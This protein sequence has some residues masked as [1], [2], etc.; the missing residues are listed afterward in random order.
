MLFSSAAGGAYWPIAIRCP[1][2]GPFPSIG[3][4]A[5]QPHTI[6]SLPIPLV[7]CRGGGGGTRSDRQPNAPAPHHS[8]VEKR[9][10]R[11]RKDRKASEIEKQALEKAY[12]VLEE[13]R[14]ARA[15][16]LTE[17]EWFSIK[18]L[19]LLT[20]KKMIYAANVPEEDLAEGNEMV[21]KVKAMAD[22][23]GT[24]P[25]P[26]GARARAHVGGG[27]AESRVLVELEA[28][29]TSLPVRWYP[30]GGLPSRTYLT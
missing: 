21:K 18:S 19:G 29:R 14:P 9:L 4:G 26:L 25:V 27:K 28:A 1:S 3:G 2:L 13:G 22:E 16:G 30:R 23:Q 5:H 10:E 15:A 11:A 12:A 8:K 17:E 24:F 20:G 7:G 6:P